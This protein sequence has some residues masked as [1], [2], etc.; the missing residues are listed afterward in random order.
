[1]ELEQAKELQ[2]LLVNLHFNRMGVCNDWGDQK[3][4]KLGTYD[5]ADWVT[6]NS[7][8]R[9]SPDLSMMIFTDALLAELYIRT[10]SQGF[11]TDIDVEHIAECA[12]EVLQCPDDEYCVVI[13]E[14][15]GASLCKVGING[16][17]DEVVREEGNAADLYQWLNKQAEKLEE[18]GV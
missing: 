1:M 14:S 9:N 4:E 6:A 15:G 18:F 11:M 7:M 8:I 3:T 16:L 2:S 10:V 17:P 13:A 5:L 12:P